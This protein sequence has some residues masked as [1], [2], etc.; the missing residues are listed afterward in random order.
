MNKNIL[1]EEGILKLFEENKKQTL[2]CIK[3]DW[4]LG[5]TSGNK[6]DVE[7]SDGDYLYFQNDN[8]DQMGLKVKNAVKHFVT[9]TNSR[10]RKF[11]DILKRISEDEE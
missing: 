5:I 1:D 6:Y 9:I 8:E 10:K 3:S 7:L 4:T 11:N 2:E